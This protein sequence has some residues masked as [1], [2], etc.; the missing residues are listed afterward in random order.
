MERVYGS[1]SRLTLDGINRQKAVRTEIIKR[2]HAAKQAAKKR[3]TREDYPKKDSELWYKGMS[4]DGKRV[5]TWGD[6]D[7]GEI[8]VMATPRT[9]RQGNVSQYSTF[10]QASARETTPERALRKMIV[11]VARRDNKVVRTRNESRETDGK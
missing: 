11:K 8:E 5:Y 4:A 9:L 1:T 6:S 2:I 7:R 10:S 3:S